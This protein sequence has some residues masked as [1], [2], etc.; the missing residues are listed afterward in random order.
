MMQRLLVCLG[1]AL[2]L[3]MPARAEERNALSGE[4]GYSSDVIGGKQTS[5]TQNHPG[6]WAKGRWTAGRFYVGA[7]AYSYRSSQG[8][9]T[10]LQSLFGYRQHLGDVDLELRYAYKRYPGT[11]AGVTDNSTEYRIDLTRHLGR[12]TLG[13]RA[14]WSPDN[15]GA[16]KQASWFEARGGWRLDSATEVSA[17]IG[18]R[19]QQHGAQYQAW[20]LGL[21]RRLTRTLGADVRWYDTNAHGHGQVYRGHMVAALIASF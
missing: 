12:L 16:A 21:R 14:E 7:N 15:Y 8:G 5:K 18:Q 4:F 13:G 20:N 6:V 1:L 11:H 3:A 9:H 19:R 2:A 17:L 10:E